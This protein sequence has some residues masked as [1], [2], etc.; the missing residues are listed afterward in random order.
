[1]EG[2][3]SGHSR[4]SEAEHDIELYKLVAKTIEEYLRSKG[5]D[6]KR[7]VLDV[8]IF[9][10]PDIPMVYSVAM[11]RLHMPELKWI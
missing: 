5:K 10:K 4:V 2:Q 6:P 11:N 7:F 3:P 8:Q 9:E 1:M